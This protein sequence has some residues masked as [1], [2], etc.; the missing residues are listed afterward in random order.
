MTTTAT[1]PS[2]LVPSAEALAAAA[3]IVAG[4]IKG[5]PLGKRPGI[6]LMCLAFDAGAVLPDHIAQGPI[7]LHTVSGEVKVDVEG[8]EVE[9]GLG[10]VLHIDSR[11]EHALRAPVRSRVLLTLFDAISSDEPEVPGI[12]KKHKVEDP[13]NGSADEAVN[14]IPVH[15]VSGQGVSGQSGDSHDGGCGCGEED[16][17]LPDLDVRAIPHAIRH[18]TV[19]GALQGLRPSQAMILTAHHNPL[20]LLRQIEQMFRGAIEVSYV[21]EGPEVWKLRLLRAS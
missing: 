10:G 19:F 18:A 7:I 13:Q 9:L 11:I 4:E 1:A 20:P 6:T 5:Y 15:D 3:P 12:I 17:N 21:E 2:I 8:S 16:E 14:L